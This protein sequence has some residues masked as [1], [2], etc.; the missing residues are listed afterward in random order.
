MSFE[1]DAGSKLDSAC[2]KFGHT[3]YAEISKGQIKSFAVYN[4]KA[5]MGDGHG[6]GKQW[7]AIFRLFQ[8]VLP[9]SLWV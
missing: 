6:T 7:G 9:N 8:N 4:I 2:S 1:T 3:L 5:Q